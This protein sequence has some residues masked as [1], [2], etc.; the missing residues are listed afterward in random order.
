MATVRTVLRLFTCYPSFRRLG[1]DAQR[2][3]IHPGG[4]RQLRRAAAQGRA[5]QFILGQGDQD[6]LGQ[7]RLA[8]LEMATATSSPATPNQA[9]PGTASGFSFATTS[10]GRI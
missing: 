2:R 1:V 3:D 7:F 6:R 5:Q 9:L 10:A 4:N 8:I